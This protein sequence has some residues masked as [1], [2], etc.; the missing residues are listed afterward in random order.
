VG[1]PGV[2]PLRAALQSNAM[3]LFSKLAEDRIKDAIARGAFDDLPCKGKP[4][5]LDDLSR[6]PSDL[7]M[8]YMLLKNAGMLPEELELRQST[9]RLRD[10]IEAC[11][12]EASRRPLEQELRAKLLKLEILRERAKR[13]RQAW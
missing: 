4:L 5:E 3:S 13:R 2:R 1:R 9:L 8:S 12:D 11:G 10:L 7:R 6:V